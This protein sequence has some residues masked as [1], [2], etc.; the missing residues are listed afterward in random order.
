MN[1]TERL[2]TALDGRYRLERELGAGGMATVYLAHDARHDRRVAVKVLR[3]ELSAILG[4]ERFVAEIRT[5]ANLQHPHIL[6]LFESGEAAGLVYYVMPFVDGESLRD[7]LQRDKQLPVDEALRIAREVADA[8]AYAHDRGIVHRDI[9]PENI[10]LHGDHAV[11]ADFGIALAASRSDG[12]SRMTETGMSLGTPQYMSPEQAM[13]ERKITP[14][15]DIYALGC[16]LYEMLSAEPPFMGASAQVIVAR[17]LTEEPRSL[18]QQRKTIP[19]HVDAAVQTALSK[20]P[21]DRFATAREFSEA[22]VTPGF[23]AT[24]ASATMS[25]PT[26][27]R[28]LQLLPWGIAGVMAV[29]AAAGW[30]RRPEVEAP[31]SRERTLVRTRPV[32]RGALALAMAISRDGSTIVYSDSVGGGSRLFLKRRDMLAVT[33]LSGTDGATRPVFSP[34]GDSIAFAADGKVKRM[35]LSGGAPLLVADGVNTTIPAIAWL[36]DG[37]ILYNNE[38]YALLAVT[39]DGESRNVVRVAE[40]RRGVVDVTP[41]P[42]SRGALITTCPG[43]CTDSDL[44]VLD[45]QADTVRMLVEETAQGWYVADGS[46]VFTRRDGSVLK[47]PFDLESL[48]FI[49]QP[50]PVLDGVR[51]GPGGAD[52]VL[53]TKGTLLYVAGEAT[54]SGTNGEV[55]WVSR[56]GQVTLVDSTWAPISASGNGGISLSPDGTRLAVVHQSRDSLDIWIKDLRSGAFSRITFEGDNQRPAWSVDGRTIFYTSRNRSGQTNEDLFQ[57]R[58]DG[59]GSEKR[60]HDDDRPV[61]EVRPTR[62]STQFV[63]RVN[64]PNRDIHLLTLGADSTTV[65]PLLTESFSES[66]PVLSPDERWLAYTSNESGRNEVYVR[67]FPGVHS[68][69]WQISRDGGAEPLWAHSGRELFYRGPERY[70]LAHVNTGESFALGEQRALFPMTGL[71][72]SASA[73]GSAI[74]LDDRRFLFLRQIQ[75]QI[76]PNAGPTELIRVDNWLTELRRKR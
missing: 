69:R 50:V 43:G 71:F 68:G 61:V 32:A 75:G 41:L 76:V 37:T 1:Q 44:R 8:L 21:A 22:L 14:R 19:P 58:A 45:L 72:G 60:L 17:V 12:S 59:T 13:G 47:A 18:T 36:D 2:R 54:G 25:R 66:Q 20:L 35:A 28:L 34:G 29:I 49:G 40:I 53:S 70:M 38:N 55:V 74:S 23:T 26:A 63:I 46:V 24:R 42:G 5:T 31:V 56:D 7:R 57:R 16:V 11:V 15:A 62:D 48:T 33:E 27:R 64:A 10:L 65:R 39:A 30:L 67:P 3:P 73:L 9:K 52:L 4:A 51:T 6:S